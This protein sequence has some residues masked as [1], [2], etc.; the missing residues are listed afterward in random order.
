MDRLSLKNMQFYGYHGAYVAEKELGQHIEVDIDMFGDFSQSAKTDDVDLSIS[1]IDVYTVVKDIVEEQ[2][3]NLLEALAEAIASQI[4]SS[5]DVKKVV[6]RVRKPN[7][8]VGGVIDAIEVE[9]SR[10]A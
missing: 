7:P 1:Y 8:S 5:F 6:V 3:F 9:I 2:E 10:T 4:L